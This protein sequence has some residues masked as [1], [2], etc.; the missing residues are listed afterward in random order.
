MN[1]MIEIQDIFNEFGNEY[2]RNHKGGW[3][4]IPMLGIA[5]TFTG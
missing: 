4:K 5:F 3:A 2:R 1:K